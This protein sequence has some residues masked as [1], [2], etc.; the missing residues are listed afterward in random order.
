MCTLWQKVK[1]LQPQF[2]KTLKRC[3][4]KNVCFDFLG[5]EILVIENFI[6]RL[7]IL[8]N[9]QNIDGKLDKYNAKI[10]IKAIQTFYIEVES[11]KKV[12]K[13]KLR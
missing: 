4:Y 13:I 6:N 12:S 10:N 5:K 11:I 1:Q 7:G 3:G 9:N 8:F 2:L